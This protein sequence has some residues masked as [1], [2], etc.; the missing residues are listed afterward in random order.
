MNY[1]GHHVLGSTTPDLTNSPLAVGF[2]WSDTSDGSVKVCTSV[3]PVTFAALGTGSIAESGVTFSDITT[4]DVSSTKH[5]YAPKSPGDATKFLNGAATPA[6]AAVKDSDLSTSDITTNDV[7]TSKHGFAPKLPNDATKFLDGTGAYSV[8]AG[9]SGPVRYAV[10]VG[11]AD[12]STAEVTVISFSVP[13][14]EMADKNT[15]QIDFLILAKNG[16]AGAQTPTIKVKWG[17]TSVTLLTTAWSNGNVENAVQARLT[18]FRVGSDLYLREGRITGIAVKATEEAYTDD[19]GSTAANSNAMTKMT[20]P[21]FS[22]TQ[23]VVM[24]V[25]WGATGTLYYKVKAATAMRIPAA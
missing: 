13:A 17:A 4:G 3:S 15:I 12:N 5:G 7:S 9:G 11:E 24:T 19:L 2:L 21:T 8:P 23:T 20:A 14:N 25:Q 10:T 18:L 22:S 1:A 16:T 6:F